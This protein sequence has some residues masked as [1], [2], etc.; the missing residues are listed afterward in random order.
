MAGV[1]Y[2][3]ATP[4][5][6][7]N[8]LTPRMEQAFNEADFIAAEDTRVTVKLLNHLGIKKPMISYY[9]HNLKDKGEYIISRVLAGE[10][11]AVCSDAG[12]PC[13]SDPGEILVKQAHAHGI[14]VIPVSGPSAVITA[15]SVSGQ[16]TGRFCFEGFLSTNKKARVDHL[17]QVK[18]ETRTMIFYEAPHKLLNTLKDFK[19]CFGADRSLTIARELTKLHE[20]IWLTTVGEAL[21]FYTENP[22]K[23][24]FVLI[25]AGGVFEREEAALTLDD[26][27]QKCIDIMESENVPMKEAAKIA[28]AK[29]NFSKSEIYKAALALRG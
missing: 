19:E 11:C 24:E 22:P 12:T 3:V 10:N 1:I 15:L 20:Q 16:N 18:T 9:E 8:D 6:N 21:D 13:I 2:V 29:T 25:V 5:G 4:I 23:G 14:R 26:L 17:E 28:S 27:A 7:L